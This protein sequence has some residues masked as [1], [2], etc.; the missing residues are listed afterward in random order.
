MAA[1]FTY[2]KTMKILLISIGTRGDME[3]FLAIGEILK[4]RG[5]KVLCAFPEQFRTLAEGSGLG[6]AS[7]G[8]DY[9]QTLESETGK[10]AM[11]GGGSGLKQFRAMIKLSIK[12]TAVNKALVLRQY[13]ILEAEKPDRVLYNG[14]ALIPIFWGLDKGEE[15]ILVCP[16]PYMHD[17][18]DH[19]HVAFSRDLGP[20]LNRLT[21]RLA[22]LGMV[23]ALKISAKWLNMGTKITR[24]ELYKALASGRAIYT[25]SPSLF[26]RPETWREGLQ[27]LG[28]HQRKQPTHWQPDKGL[29]EFLARHKRDR[30]LL[31]TFGSM[32]NP[33]PAEKTKIIVDILERHQIPAILNTASGGLV[34]L[35]Q[36]NPDLIH[37]VAGIPYGWIL[38]QIY[39]VI[40]HGGSGTTHLGL[41]YGCATMIIPHVVDQ[42]AWNDRVTAIGAGPR[43]MKIGHMTTKLLAP[44]ILDLVRNPVYKAKAE[45]VA[46][47]MGEEDFREA[48]YQSIIDGN[49]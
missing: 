49:G 31:V 16:L 43:G 2:R 40:H 4:E 41:K 18:K 27:V 1:G 20:L 29:I 7:L 26:P 10:A 44:K 14:K 34:R 28:F 8:P 24:K 45:Q 25:I 5:Q 13:E 36:Y 17:M 11:G 21:Y 32:T 9:I 19:P 48:I 38:P 39:G 12:Q 30:P 46:R 47:Q 35:Q 22:D 6:F 23:E 37:F 15:P 33:N 42:F 3:P